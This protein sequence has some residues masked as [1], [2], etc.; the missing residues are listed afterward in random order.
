MARSTRGRHA[1]LGLLAT[2]Y[3]ALWVALA[4]E[5]HD[6]ADWLLENA[7]VLLFGAALLVTRRWFAFSR[8][9]YTL[10]FLFLCLHAVGAHYTYSLVP[11]DD[12][13]R[14]LTGHGLNEALGWRRNHFDRLVHF[15]YGLLL[16]YPIRE[17]FL[18]VV[19]VRGFWGYLLPLDVALSTSALYE[20]IEWGAAAAFGGE[21]GAAYLG[22]QGDVWDA[23]KDMALAACGACIAMVATALANRGARRD[24]AREW[25][26]SLKPPRDDD[27]A[28]RLS[29]PAPASGK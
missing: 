18:R 3:A 29:P 6:R 10:I 20:L 9:S 25:A 24:L 21:L 15:S 22:T 5:P 13:W 11:Y 28:G 12:W 4:I 2:L 8:V 14:A 27:A 7:L 26:D 23:H 1:Y 16:A 19:E 17:I